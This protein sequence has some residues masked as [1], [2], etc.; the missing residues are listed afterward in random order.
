ML[1]L[2]VLEKINQFYDNN[3]DD[4]LL[5]L[6]AA[7]FEIE[8]KRLLELCDG[9]SVALIPILNHC[10]IVPAGDTGVT[11]AN[12]EHL[13]TALSCVML[14]VEYTRKLHSD[15][16]EF[17]QKTGRDNLSPSFTNLF[18]QASDQQGIAVLTKGISMLFW[19]E[20]SES[21]EVADEKGNESRANIF[22]EADPGQK[23]SLLPIIKS[24]PLFLLNH[25]NTHEKLKNKQVI[26]V[27]LLP[28]D[29]GVLLRLYFDF[30]DLDFLTT[31]ALFSFGGCPN[32][33]LGCVEYMVEGITLAEMHQVMHSDA[34]NLDEDHD[35]PATRKVIYLLAI[36]SHIAA[37]GDYVHLLGDDQLW[38]NAFTLEVNEDDFIPL[39]SIS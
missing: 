6:D 11:V 29:Q 3:I 32:V 25:H 28:A 4:D 27:S 13:N 37:E 18:D 21:G 38:V 35:D 24:E 39:G 34:F 31:R 14:L 5:S 22:V 17:V 20:V 9:Y 23:T 30:T 1:D 26:T 33:R 8:I 7:S 19:I 16:I 36:L 10:G 2:S 12:A 15:I